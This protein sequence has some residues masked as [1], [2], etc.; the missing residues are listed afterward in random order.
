MSR[1]PDCYHARARSATA[2]DSAAADLVGGKKWYDWQMKALA[3]AGVEVLL[4]M[5]HTPPSVTEGNAC[6]SPPWWLKYHADGH[7]LRAVAVLTPA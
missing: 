4:S 2:P 3:E 1:G 5:W 7:S 6:N